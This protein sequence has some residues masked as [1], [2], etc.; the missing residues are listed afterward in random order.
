MKPIASI[1]TPFTSVV[2]LAVGSLVLGGCTALPTAPPSAKTFVWKINPMPANTNS[3]INSVDIS[4]DGS[5][6][7]AGNFFHQYK[8]GTN[9]VYVPPTTNTY[10]I[11]LWNAAGTLQWS[12]TFQATEGAYWVGL[13]RDGA[14]AAGGGMIAPGTGFV[15][16]YDAA[17]GTKA[18]N[19][20]TRGRV[21]R[22]ALSGDGSYLVAGAEA[23]Y[24]FQRTGASWSAPQIIPCGTNDNV[25]SVD[26]SDDGQWMVTGTHGVKYGDGAHGGV[27]QLLQNSNGVV[28][29]RGSWQQPK[30]SFTHWVAMAANGSGCVVGADDASAYYFSTAGFGISN[31]PTWTATLDGCERCGCVAISSDGSLV[32]AVGNASGGGKIFLFA[33]TN[34]AAMPLW[35]KATAHDP[36]GTSFD[37]AGKFITVTDGYKGSGDFYLYDQAGNLQWSY[38]TKKMTWPMKIS[39]NAT[40]I[41]AGTDDSNVYFFLP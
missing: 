29:V 18:L 15:F 19:Y 39:G 23:T 36:N 27:V 17:T 4:G 5:R 7:I 9:T 8:D 1:T 41:V 11:F 2:A 26:I 28:V 40:G 13:S 22:L 35:A 10:G 31:A 14:W 24:F 12:D 34:G 3:Y 21:S 20:A 16:A 30:D 38:A 25:V 32:S 37:A 33:N 6:V